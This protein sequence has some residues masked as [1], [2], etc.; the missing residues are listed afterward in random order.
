MDLKL[1]YNPFLVQTEVFLNETEQIKKGNKLECFLDSR[2]Q[3]WDYDDLVQK[4]FEEFNEREIN[5][6]FKGREMDFEDFQ[7]GFETA[8]NS[9]NIKFNFAFEQGSKNKDIINRLKKLFQKIEEGPFEELKTEEIKRIFERS[10]NSEF[11]ISVLA[12]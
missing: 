8:K 6:T 12:T 9:N 5:L 2:I 3:D 1:I 7:L 10:L 11:P 4:L